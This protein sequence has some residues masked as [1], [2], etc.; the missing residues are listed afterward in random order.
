MILLAIKNYDP[1]IALLRSALLS[2]EEL[3][4]V[5]GDNVMP[6]YINAI[7]N[8][9]YPIITI[10]MDMSQTLKSNIPSSE[11]Y[12]YVY[13]WTKNGPDEASYLFNLTVDTI[14]QKPPTGLTMCR[15]VQGR[16]P[17]Y[18]D[19]TRTHYFMSKYLIYVPKTL[20]YT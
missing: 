8:P 20:M 4:A 11:C 19:E 15:K 3:Y 17:L 1:V 6:D 18:Y 9:T 12:Y 10:H 16:S 2:N 14:D 7:D 5:I 13:G